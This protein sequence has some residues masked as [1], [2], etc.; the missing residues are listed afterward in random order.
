MNK[1]N[2]ISKVACLI[3]Y[4]L[5]ASF[6]AYFTASSLS[7]NLLQ[8]TNM[9]IVFIMV[10]VVALLAGWCLN[11]V[12]RELS[13]TNGASRTVFSFSFVGFLLFWAISFTTNV[14]Y[15][16]VQKHG[17]DILTKELASAK[18]YVQDNTSRSDRSIDDMRDEAKRTIQAQINNSM[19]A[20]HREIENTR[21]HRYGFGDACITIL[22]SMETMLRSDSK[23]YND[24]NEYVIFKEQEDGGDKGERRY[25]Q[26]GSLF[27]KY[28]GRVNT[29]LNR[30][31][32]V[33]DEYYEKKK[34]AN[35][36]LEEL[37]KPIDELE[38]KH[39]PSVARDGSIDAFYKYCTKQNE[40]VISK[41]PAAYKDSCVVYKTKKEQAGENVKAVKTDEV[42]KYTVYPS[43]RMFDSIPVWGDVL[44]GRLVGLTMLQ[45]IIISLIFDVVSF[46]LLYLFL[47]Q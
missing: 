6:S 10:M 33:I 1:S 47:K 35:T 9:W 3:G 22:K 29:A 12:I 20:F 36:G 32:A 31:L 5:F 24:K 23:I 18:R 13:K 2:L 40:D 21:E 34:N 42:K 15:F 44:F 17:F 25:N 19:D 46:I 38:S 4:L 16:F 45:W 37:L 30:K 26:L 43:L 39:L 27:G 14:H 41:M 7:L 28:A 8:G 11:N